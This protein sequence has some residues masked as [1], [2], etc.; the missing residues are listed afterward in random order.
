[1]AKLKKFTTYYRAAQVFR[2]HNGN[3]ARDADETAI[4]TAEDGS[5][6]AP[7]GKGSFVLT[8][9]FRIDTDQPNPY[10]LL[11]APRKTG[12]IGTMSSL[13][14]SM[15][16]RGAT[17]LK[18]KKL[19]DIPQN[20][21]LSRYSAVPIEKIAGKTQELLAKREAQTDLMAQWLKK[22]ADTAYGARLAEM[23]IKGDALA[24]A[25]KHAEDQ[26]IGNL[27][28][29]LLGLGQKQVDLT[30][31]DTVQEILDTTLKQS[32]IVLTPEQLDTLG[33]AASA[34]NAQ[35]EDAPSQQ[36]DL[37]TQIG[38]NATVLV[39]EQDYA[40]IQ[41]NY[42]GDA[43]QQ[44]FENNDIY[45][46]APV[47]AALADDTGASA[48]DGVTSDAT[49]A[50]SGMVSAAAVSV[51]VYRDGERVGTVPAA[52]GAWSFASEAL[53]DGHY[54]FAAAGVNAAGKEGPLSQALDVT[55]DA[56]P[57]AVPTVD[58]L[59]TANRTPTL[60]GTWSGAADETL[61][62][63]V[64]GK[65]YT[66]ENGLSVSGQTWSLAIPGGDALAVG[67]YDAVARVVDL[68]GNVSDDIG[69]PELT[70]I[71]S[72]APIPPASLASSI[73]ALTDD[74]GASATDRVTRD[75][76]PTLSGEADKA[77]V[78]VQI[79]R[80][81]AN[82]G[83]AA[84]SDGAW[85]YASPALADNS[86][87]FTAKAMNGEGREGDASAPFTVVIDTQAPGA[88]TVQALATKDSTPSLSGTWSGG[89]GESLSL[90]VNGKT[91][92]PTT[93]G[94]AWSLTIP[95]G[96]ALAAGVYEVTATATDLAGNASGDQSA[97]ELTVE[98]QN[99]PPPPRRL[100]RP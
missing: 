16:D 42:T 100:R 99:S 10:T 34:I 31:K 71:D 36:L 54:R 62:V 38:A 93:G 91:Y 65:T 89:A 28:D 88:P 51:N 25:L 84:V 3:G 83:A 85:T 39:G 7:S 78:Q 61:S 26:A 67:V 66:V 74:T 40:A 24:A 44:Q 19:L 33:Q 22:I 58:P 50:A 5:F 52:N 86:Y 90:N 49:P 2:D 73:A 45:I 8:G 92:A 82:V 23:G 75:T 55:V 68:A 64:N 96:D 97:K 81:G 98:A 43:V 95:D 70:I 15:L 21:Q 53:A 12:G 1:M 57:P 27:A 35:I 14:Q 48:T 4:M 79:Y 32:N 11:T 20:I 59:K 47:I 76:T 69:G 56:T 63:S 37:A 41:D 72:S 6:M 77:A 9:G 18:I 94:G 46:A 80:D 30:D 13:W 60:A 87:V 29:T 17:P